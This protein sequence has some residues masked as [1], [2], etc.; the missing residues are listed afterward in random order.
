MPPK[1]AQKK[2]KKVAPKKTA[3]KKEVEK[4]EEIVEQVTEVV[5]KVEEQVPAPV[6][7]PK[8]KK[9][10]FTVFRI[11]VDDA[12]KLEDGKCEGRYIGT[13]PK[14]A[15]RKA[16][17]QI[18]KKL[19]NESGV[20]FPAGKEVKFSI[21]ETTQGNRLKNGDYHVF[22]YIGKLKESATPKEIE[23]NVPKNYDKKKVPVGL[24]VKFGGDPKKNTY[25]L[26][27]SKSGK[28]VILHKHE[29]LISKDKSMSV[30]HRKTVASLA[31]E[32][33]VEPVPEPKPEP[34]KE[35]VVT[36]KKSAPKPKSKAKAKAK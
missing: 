22:N 18:V 9:R 24:S 27:C 12:E 1:V 11:F 2:D 33:P 16:F 23:R 15:G 20:D 35:K 30:K 26:I 25:P 32:L 5:K 31:V 29:P 34:V 3:P 19:E 36:P 28:L 13:A 17:R 14:Q 7:K 21:R 6:E 8:K 4:I 10:S